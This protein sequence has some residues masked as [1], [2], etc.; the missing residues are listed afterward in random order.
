MTDSSRHLV[1][2]KHI[3]DNTA[4]IDWVLAIYGSYIG[5]W[6]GL[7]VQQMWENRTN[8]VALFSDQSYNDG[9]AFLI[10]IGF[11]VLFFV[12]TYYMI[13]WIW[14]LRSLSPQQTVKEVIKR[15]RK[16]GGGTFYFFI[17]IGL[18]IIGWFFHIDFIWV[19]AGFFAFI[20]WLAIILFITLS[21]RREW[22]S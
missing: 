18:F 9:L 2:K 1:N 15:L 8:V 5:I 22:I 6:L 20:S 4:I 14:V 7:F 11:P 13:K 21:D 17:I 16:S 19:F 12:F 10:I 3:E